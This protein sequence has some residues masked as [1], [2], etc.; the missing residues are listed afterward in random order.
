MIME[1]I[2]RFFYQRFPNSNVMFNYR[3]G[4]LGDSKPEADAAAQRKTAKQS[5]RK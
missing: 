3:L 5:S 1:R 2:K 4:P